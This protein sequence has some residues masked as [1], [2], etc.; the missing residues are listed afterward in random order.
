MGWSLTLATND[1]LA[2]DLDLLTAVWTAA[3]GTVVNA[4][5]YWNSGDWWRFDPA[6]KTGSSQPQLKVSSGAGS[7]VYKRKWRS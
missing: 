7:L 4:L 1:T 2:V 5:Q 6:D 3:T